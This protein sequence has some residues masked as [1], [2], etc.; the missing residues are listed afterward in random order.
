ML[1]HRHHSNLIQ[2]LVKHVGEGLNNAY[3]A[4]EASWWIRRG[5]KEANT[6]SLAVVIVAFRRSGVVDCFHITDYLLLPL[7]IWKIIWILK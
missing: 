1:I 5:S 3:M 6:K 7:D 4:S 2:H